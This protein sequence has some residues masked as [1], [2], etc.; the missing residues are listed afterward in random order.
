[1]TTH[2]AVV[3]PYAV[4]LFLIR[5]AIGDMFGPVADLC[6]EEAV[7]QLYGP[8]P[9]HEVEAILAALD[10]VKAKLSERRSDLSE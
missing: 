5:E 7:L 8:E 3:E 6:S 9:I 2:F 4:A 1:M 10:R